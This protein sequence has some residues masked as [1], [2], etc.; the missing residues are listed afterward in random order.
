MQLVTV[1]EDI[2]T[3]ITN[4]EGTLCT[5]GICTENHDA[6]VDLNTAEAEAL[7]YMILAT[8]KHGTR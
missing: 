2:V 5:V 8:V 1:R 7:A 3:L 6:T 4:Y